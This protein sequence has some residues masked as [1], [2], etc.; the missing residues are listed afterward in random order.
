MFKTHTVT[1]HQAQEAL[2][3]L[4][5]ATRGEELKTKDVRKSAALIQKA[6]SQIRLTADPVLLYNGLR[7]AFIV[8][9][10]VEMKQ[11]AWS[12]SQDFRTLL[13]EESADKA[14]SVLAELLPNCLKQND[15]PPLEIIRYYR[16]A[17]RKITP[18]TNEPEVQVTETNPLGFSFLYQPNGFV[19]GSLDKRFVYPEDR[20]MVEVA[21]PAIH[22]RAHHAGI[23]GPELMSMNQLVSAF[24]SIT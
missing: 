17:E 24:V 13:A 5:A 6:A 14:E 16:A 12:D 23:V 1:T 4:S 15:F 2:H 9:A 18:D 22:Y 3:V 21:P 20:I 19:S 7:K 10:A 8:D 11:R